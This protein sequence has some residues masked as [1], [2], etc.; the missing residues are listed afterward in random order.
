[1][2]YEQ[3]HA[4]DQTQNRL[5][6]L[7]NE[8][9]DEHLISRAIAG[10]D[11]K[12]TMPIMLLRA[13]AAPPN[14][15]Q[16]PIALIEPSPDRWLEPQWSADPSQQLELKSDSMLREPAPIVV[17]AQRPSPVGNGQQRMLLVGSG[18]WLLS[19]DA[20]LVIPIGGNR[21][22][23]VYPGNYELMLASVSWLAGMDDLIAASPMSQEVSRLR[24]LSPEA[25]TR[26][27]WILVAGLPLLCVAAGAA[28]WLMR[29]D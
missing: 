7:V 24:D 8:Y 1:V 22:A 17:A 25:R 5:A 14:V 16:T 3:V 29:R 2:I 23:L 11:A 6:Q 19:F 9:P 15:Q 10:Q 26:W 18:S 28:I 27:F 21:N 4:G 20:D 13:N 12:F